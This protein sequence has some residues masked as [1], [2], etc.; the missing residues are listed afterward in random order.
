MI[1]EG[2]TIVELFAAAGWRGHHLNYDQEVRIIDTRLNK[3]MTQD[4][5]AELVK[6]LKGW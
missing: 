4:E 6:R 3:Q 2:A 5:Y 1:Y